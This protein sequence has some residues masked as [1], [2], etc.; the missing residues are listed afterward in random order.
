MR[1]ENRLN[2][3][4][5][6]LKEYKI[7]L[8]RL[9]QIGTTIDPATAETAFFYADMNDP[10]GILDEKYHEGQSGREYFARNPGDGWVHFHD[11]FRW[12]GVGE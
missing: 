4:D 1:A 11:L 10:Y 6:D 2:S 5:V 7:E 8:E 3:D 9:R 12:M